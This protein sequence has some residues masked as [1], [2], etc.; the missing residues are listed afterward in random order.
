[1]MCKDLQVLPNEKK[2]EKLNYNST[3]AP[4]QQIWWVRW[5]M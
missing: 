5:T 3:S 1:M 2:K 4:H